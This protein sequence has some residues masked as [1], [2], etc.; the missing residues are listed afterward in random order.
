M[1]VIALDSEGLNVVR[2]LALREPGIQ[3]SFV[4]N[5]L[6]RLWISGDDGVLNQVTFSG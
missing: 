2:K 5:A 4:K 6:G 1:Y 3:T